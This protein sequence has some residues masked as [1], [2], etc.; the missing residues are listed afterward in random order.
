[1]GLIQQILNVGNFTG[2]MLLAG[3]T[4]LAGGWNWTWWVTGGFALVGIL[5]A[6]GLSRR[7]SPFEGMIA[8]QVSSCADCSTVYLG[9]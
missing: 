8:H 3:I 4:T 5:L 6:I 7:N 2:P 1:M 9:F